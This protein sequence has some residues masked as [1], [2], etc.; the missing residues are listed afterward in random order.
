MTVY[1]PTLSRYEILKRTIPAWLGQEQRLILVTDPD[2]Y[3]DH[4]ALRDEMGWTTLVRV[5]SMPKAAR[6]QGI[7]YKRHFIVEHAD[8]SGLDAIIIA[9]DDHKP[10]PGTDTSLLLKE[11][12]DDDVLGIG[13]AIPI[14]DRFTGGR[15]SQ[16]DEPIL[17]P[18]GW[19]FAVYG[20]NINNAL[21]VG[22]YDP[23]LTVGED[24][25]LWREG[26]AR[27]IP[28]RVHCGVRVAAVGKRNSPGGMT[29]RWLS[30]KARARAERESRALIHERW[31]EYTSAPDRPFRMAWA[32]MLDDYIPDWRSRSALHGG[33]L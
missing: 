29:A 11:A 4:V 20:L 15:V 3:L 8:N 7:G 23:L 31:P 10:A 25:E 9:D 16:F 28:W 32:K 33:S 30:D 26:V 19:G 24:A 27:G 17:C 12:D 18:G 14:Y 2:Q 21:R 22:S 13:A 1:I 6:G 5:V